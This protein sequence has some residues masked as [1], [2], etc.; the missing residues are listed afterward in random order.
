MKKLISFQDLNRLIQN[1]A[2]SDE[3]ASRL[4]IVVR[5]GFKPLQPSDIRTLFNQKDSKNNN[6]LQLAAQLRQWEL[7]KVFILTLKMSQKTDVF[8]E[9]LNN[10]NSDNNNL[11]DIIFK[12]QQPWSVKLQEK[13]S[14]FEGQIIDLSIEELLYAD[15]KDSVNEAI[16]NKK[17]V[18]LSQEKIQKLKTGKLENQDSNLMMGN[19]EEKIRDLAGEY[20]YTDQMDSPLQKRKFYIEIS[21]Q[22][23]SYT[24][25]SSF[26][27]KISQGKIKKIDL[28][29]TDPVNFSSLTQT[30]FQKIKEKAIDSSYADAGKIAEFR[31]ITIPDIIVNTIISIKNTAGKDRLIK[32][33]EE[34][35]NKIS[36][37]SSS[38]E[39]SLNDTMSMLKDIG[40]ELA[41]KPK[42]DKLRELE[43]IHSKYENFEYQDVEKSTKNCSTYI[44]DF[45]SAIF[46][47]IGAG[48][49]S[50]YLYQIK[51]NFKNIE[52][53]N[54]IIEIRKQL[55][56]LQDE[57][58]EFIEKYNF[59]VCE[60]IL[61]GADLTARSNNAPIKELFSSLDAIFARA[62]VSIGE[63]YFCHY[64]W[65]FN[66]KENLDLIKGYIKEKTVEVM[67][68]GKKLKDENSNFV[69]FLQ[70]FI[71]VAEIE[72]VQQLP[73]LIHE[74]FTYY[75]DYY[76]KENVG[77]QKTELHANNCRDIIKIS[78]AARDRD[79]KNL[80]QRLFANNKLLI[81]HIEDGGGNEINFEKLI[82]EI[83]WKT[84]ERLPKLFTYAQFSAL[85]NSQ[86][87]HGLSYFE[88]FI[89][90]LLLDRPL[91]TSKIS[92]AQKLISAGAKFNLPSNFNFLNQL[93]HPRLNSFLSEILKRQEDEICQIA[94][95]KF[96]EDLKEKF[97]NPIYAVIKIE[98][99]KSR[100]TVE[101]LEQNVLDDLKN[102]DMMR[103]CLYLN[104]NELS[105]NG[106]MSYKIQYFQSFEYIPLIRGFK[107]G[108]IPKL[109][110]KLQFPK[111]FILEKNSIEP[112]HITNIFLNPADDKVHIM[113]QYIKSGLYQDFVEYFDYNE[114]NANDLSQVNFLLDQ[115]EI[116]KC[117][118]VFLIRMND[119]VKETGISTVTD[120]KKKEAEYLQKL[121]SMEIDFAD[122][123]SLNRKI[124]TFNLKIH[125]DEEEALRNR[126]EM[127][128][129][130]LLLKPIDKNE[131]AVLKNAIKLEI[132]LQL[133]SKLIQGNNDIDILSKENHKI[134]SKIFAEFQK[135]GCY[136]E[137]LKRN[138][139][140]DYAMQVEKYNMLFGPTEDDIFSTKL[141]HNE[142]KH[143]SINYIKS[144]TFIEE[145]SKKATKNSQVKQLTRTNVNLQDDPLN[146]NNNDK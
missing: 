25:I 98:A 74:S 13:I 86:D 34:K 122:I 32:L 31:T 132:I 97:R 29:L 41:K 112:S 51:E 91:V 117:L 121:K 81:S 57:K 109:V 102:K 128:Q 9:I 42:I 106:N 50:V 1:S 110:I 116:G 27:G 45:C 84:V 49:T 107:N 61:C 105:I 140:H 138:N 67:Y 127:A 75:C 36:S 115:G 38:E 135:N 130:E 72:K 79:G 95:E 18:T 77:Y 144:I 100:K 59:F 55:K 39:K 60:L 90:N 48:D 113:N 71:K 89:S 119:L 83:L 19:D 70:A 131:Y 96:G 23:V 54:S 11:L 92:F 58:L 15:I 5:D 118:K 46:N 78:I 12:M 82:D 7:I 6:L 53:W 40:K 52:N 80:L 20:L 126:L 143:I 145:E 24:I 137:L 22:F 120:I 73:I 141:T 35:I 21:D 30:H 124:K 17:A 146:I 99:S 85:I 62:F 123:M 111:S 56:V 33:L 93:V 68:Q 136:W 66:N 104:Q 65:F 26:N 8:K 14:V 76:L 94:W 43:K 88:Y 129:Y 63:Y 101:V 4:L 44:S 69:K 134:D 87:N 142:S 139:I 2:Q 37:E 114:F 64:F 133:L 16:K 47:L 125:S 103:C 10:K 3:E 108:K 28:G